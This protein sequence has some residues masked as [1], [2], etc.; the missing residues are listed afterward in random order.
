VTPPSVDVMIHAGP[1]RCRLNTGSSPSA[2]DQQ[3][4]VTVGVMSDQGWW[5]WW[6]WLWRRRRLWWLWCVVSGGSGGAGGGGSGVGSG[7]CDVWSVVVAVV[8]GQ[9][10]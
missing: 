1:Y 10:W 4:V 2:G 7:G 6:Q 3:T 5:R 9:W 8:C